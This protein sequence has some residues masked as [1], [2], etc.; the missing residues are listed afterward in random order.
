M[1]L[2]S[3]CAVQPGARCGSGASAGGECGPAEGGG[4]ES[5]GSPTRAPQGAVR[6]QR[7]EQLRYTAG[8]VR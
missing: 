8:E 5:A 6:W 4:G 7:A 2:L 1:C 3:V